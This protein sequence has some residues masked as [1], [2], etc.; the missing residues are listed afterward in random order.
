MDSDAS[1]RIVSDNN[2]LHVAVAGLLGR[3]SITN[4]KI[5]AEGG[6]KFR[7]YCPKRLLRLCM[8]FY[9]TRRRFMFFVVLTAILISI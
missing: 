8:D 3:Y 2:S 1:K 6:G 7:K 4:Y 5:L 9:S